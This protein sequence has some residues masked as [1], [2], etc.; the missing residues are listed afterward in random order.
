MINARSWQPQVT[1]RADCRNHWPCSWSFRWMDKQEAAFRAW[2]NTVLAPAPADVDG[3]SEGNSTASHRGLASRRLTARLRGLL[4]QLYSQDQEL[5][6]C[7]T[8][9]VLWNGRALA[10]CKAVAK[11]PE[12]L[13]WGL[14][15]RPFPPQSCCCSVML[16]VEQRID[17][18]QLKLRDEVGRPPV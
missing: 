9:L 4:W 3:S 12:P 5:V 1:V 11:H 8:W 13:P 18:G 6:R 16:K 17:S 7:V 10:R 2:L 14:I 15:F